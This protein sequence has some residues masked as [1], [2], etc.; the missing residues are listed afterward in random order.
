M[1]SKLFKRQEQIIKAVGVVGLWILATAYVIHIYVRPF[2]F[3]LLDSFIHTLFIIGG[4]V[5]LENVFRFYVP[6]SANLWLAFILPLFLTAIVLFLGSFGL[7]LLLDETEAYLEFIDQS[8]AL[9]GLLI[10]ILFASWGILLWMDGQLEDQLKTRQREAMI[11]QMTKDAELSLLRQK[12]QP[13]FL[14]NSLNSISA[15]VKNNPDQARQ[16][17]IQLS[18][19][20]RGTIQKDDRKW[21]KMEEEVAF[22]N[23][24]LDIEMIRFGHRLQVIFNLDEE[25]VALRLPQLMIQPLLENALKHGLYGLTGEVIIKLDIS[26]AGSFLEI[27]IS[28]PFD[29]QAGKVKGAGFGLQA[30]KRRL[31]LL[32]GRNDLLIC[33]AEKD[34]FTV[35]L[36]IPQTYD[37]DSNH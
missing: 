12:L 22:L 29:P 19:F 37:P 20:L 17:V 34:V 16:M 23:L 9:R 18:D 36:K 28:N 2:S 30:V 21:L 32:F 24:F 33:T 8:Y 31:Y 5:L 25:A 11:Q 10:L 1:I 26:K 6:R 7:Q 3:A 4:F 27:R 35:T 15:L 13:H 14:F